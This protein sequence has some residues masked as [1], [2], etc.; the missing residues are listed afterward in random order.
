MWIIDFK[1]NVITYISHYPRIFY[2]EIEKYYNHQICGYE[3]GVF[4]LSGRSLSTYHISMNYMYI[5]MLFIL[6]S[7]LL[8]FLCMGTYMDNDI[9]D[10][11]SSV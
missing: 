5:E 1:Y 6:K 11:F 2:F 4:W 7:N 8:L 9:Y 3:D 10:E